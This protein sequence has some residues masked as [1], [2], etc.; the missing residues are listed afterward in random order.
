[1][2]LIDRYV[3]G[4]V[5][6][7]TLYGVFVLS[8]VLVLGNVFKE[9]LDLLVNR[10]VPL[11]YLV[12]FVLCVLPFSMTYTIPWAF[13]AAVL[14]VFGRM[15]ADHEFTALRACGTSLV[16]VSLPVL[17]LGLLLSLLTL[18]INISVAPRAELAMRNSL[19]DMARSNPASLLH[20]GEVITHFRGHKIFVEEKRGDEL[21]NVTIVKLND[22]AQPTSLITA[23]R[24]AVT[25]SPDGNQLVLSLED[26]RAES[27]T[28]GR[29][30]DLRGI[31]HGMAATEFTMAVSLDE[32]VD[33][34][35]LWRPLRTFRT[36]EL[37]DLL[38]Q[39][40]EEKEWP[41]RS[42]VLTEI[43]K[44]FS[45]AGA[46]IAFAFLAMPLGIAAH[47]RETSV[48]FGISIAVAFGYFFFVAMSHSMQNNA[49]YYPWLLLWT[50]NILFV[51]V[52]IWLLSRL[53]HRAS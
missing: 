37:F 15:S 12:F 39:N 25:T 5:L 4:S 24:G 32:L 10:D 7:A 36:G 51:G 16:R 43:S 31:Q 9:A 38:S 50:P 21:R 18:W 6:T 17:A 47:R 52:G 45:L 2:T 35:L 11:R 19:A 49:A 41:S 46:S 30:T 22:A 3:G 29:E 42:S 20:P 27:R 34:G 13:L 40:L 26:A 8:L 33:S 23:R 48:G 53:D 44:R 1:M 28:R 14:L